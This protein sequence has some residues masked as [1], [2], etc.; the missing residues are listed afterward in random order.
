MPAGY[1]CPSHPDCRRR[2]GGKPGCVPALV[3]L[4]G[5]NAPHRI[6]AEALDLGLPYRRHRDANSIRQLAA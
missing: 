2:Y 3:K 4:D 5:G 1:R 6:Q